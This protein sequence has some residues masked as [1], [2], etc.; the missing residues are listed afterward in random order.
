MRF[1]LRLGEK[2]ALDLPLH[3]GPEGRQAKRQPSP[4]GLVFI[5]DD[6]ERRRRDTHSLLWYSALFR[7]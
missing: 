7:C 3:R 1:S 6:D 5:H 4:E 2:T